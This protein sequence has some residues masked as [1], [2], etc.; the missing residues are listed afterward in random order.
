VGLNLSQR[1]IT[2]FFGFLRSYPYLPKVIN[3]FT[4]EPP[5]IPPK[6]RVNLFP[7]PLN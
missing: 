4:G 2:P 6:G 1:N 7:N 3:F 5:K